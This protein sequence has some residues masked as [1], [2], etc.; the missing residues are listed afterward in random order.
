LYKRG[1]LN[2]ISRT[3]RVLDELRGF[4]RGRLLSEIAS[5]LGASE[6]TIRRDLA[7]LRSA[8]FEIESLTIAGRAAARLVEKTYSNVAITRRERYTL[9]AIGSLFDVLRGTPLWEDVKSLQAKLAQRMSPEEREEHATFG[10]RFA[11]VP[12]GGTKAYDGKEDVL[13][14][15]LTGV[16]SR[17]IVKF[18]YRDARGR[19]RKG[20]IAPYTMVLYKHGLYVIGSRVRDPDNKAPDRADRSGSE[21]R[22]DPEMETRTGPDRAAGAEPD[23]ASGT[24]QDGTDRTGPGQVDRAAPEKPERHVTEP[25]APIV[26]YAVERFTEAEALRNA[27]FVI[28]AGF[29]IA[30]VLNGAFGIHVAGPDTPPR[31]V[32]IEFSAAKAA[33]VR[34]RIWHP[35]QTF[36]ELP[37]GRVR[38]AFTCASLIPVVSWVLEWGPHARAIEPPALVA[39]VIAE[40]DAARRGYDAPPEPAASPAAAP[41]DGT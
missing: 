23:A 27:P 39:D 11:Y 6:R 36:E 4:R 29:K 17:R 7:D 16:L 2:H 38:L 14:A 20:R 13:D 1:D 34:A 37:D 32:V 28:P 18:A 25:I 15:L 26:V 24:A 5:Q 21:P 12:D 22:T 9:L 41:A 31:R 30:D 40:L 19:V 10:E 33:F 35:T 3:L 8:G